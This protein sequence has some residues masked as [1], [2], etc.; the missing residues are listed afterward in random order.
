MEIHSPRIEGGGCHWPKEFSKME[1]QLRGQSCSRKRFMT[2][3]WP[4]ESSPALLKDLSQKGSLPSSIFSK[5]VS[6]VG[7]PWSSAFTIQWHII[8]IIECPDYIVSQT[9]LWN[10]VILVLERT[11]LITCNPVIGYMRQ[12]FAQDHTVSCGRSPH[13][14]QGHSQLSLFALVCGSHWLTGFTISESV[15]W[16]TTNLPCPLCGN[17]PTL[18]HHLTIILQWYF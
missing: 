14:T 9:K 10:H 11:F 2:C 15:N 8:K 5:V 1:V 3:K 18:L 7:F 16:M 17:L 6:L 12:W 4:Q 13:S